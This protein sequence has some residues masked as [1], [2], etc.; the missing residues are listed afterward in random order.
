MS[1]EYWTVS[2]GVAPRVTTCRCCKQMIKPG[3]AITCRDGRKI[4]LT[5][6]R[7]CF[8]GESDPRTQHHSSFEKSNN[9]FHGVIGGSAPSTK[10]HGKWSTSSYG[11]LGGRVVNNK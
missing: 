7:E 5:Y 11:M 10:G 4:R 8:S 3:D 1:D 6:H 2:T 9:K